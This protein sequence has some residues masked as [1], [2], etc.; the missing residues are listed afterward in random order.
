MLPM[1]Q[2]IRKVSLSH[3]DTRFARILDRMR[4][5]LIAAPMFLVSGVDLV[6]AACCN[7]VIGSFPTANC[8]TPEELAQWLAIIRRRLL[9]HEETAGTAAAPF[10][11][12]LI[13]HASNS[14]LAA[15]LGV[16]LAHSPQL[17]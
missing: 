11:P 15:D 17:G 1:D 13:V 14:R 9:D 16:V 6:A 8:R 10:C 3:E 7:G 12:N 4:L 5:P 2:S